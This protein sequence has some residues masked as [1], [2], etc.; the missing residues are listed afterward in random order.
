MA[1]PLTDVLPVKGF[2]PTLGLLLGMLED[3]T[4]KWRSELGEVAEE[5]LIWQPFPNGHSI[6]ALILHMADVEAWWLHEVGA[7]MPRTAEERAR[8]LSEETRQY[9]VRWPRPPARPLTWYFEQQEAIRVRTREIVR[10]LDGAEQVCRRQRDGKEFTVR[11][12]LHHVIN[13]EAYHGGQAVL[14]ALM[15][16]E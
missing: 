8:L 3:G 2:D 1:I 10:G 14:L 12:L 4:T 16:R 11:W 7:G 13:H 9:Q 15:Q 6:G 5:A